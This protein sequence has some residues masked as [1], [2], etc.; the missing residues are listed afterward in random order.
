MFCTSKTAAMALLVCLSV[1]ASAQE[2]V[3]FDG[4]EGEESEGMLQEPAM[5]DYNPNQDIEPVEQ[6][7]QGWASDTQLSA[8]ENEEVA[9]L[10]AA[11]ARSEDQAM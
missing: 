6:I 9:E 7:E 1:C 4:L 11:D 5:S 2:G 3:M 10:Q 8:S